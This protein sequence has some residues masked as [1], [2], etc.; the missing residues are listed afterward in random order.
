MTRI[1]LIAGLLVSAAASGAEQNYKYIGDIPSACPIT[2]KDGTTPHG[3]R[4]KPQQAV[5]LAAKHSLVK[6]NSVFEQSVYADENNYYIIK[7]AF[8]PMNANADA[9][10]ING[11][12][13][14]VII[15]KQ[16]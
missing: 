2:I 5:E 8:G 13:G 9:V 12:S 7:P 3:F 4:V 11:R 1:Y 10:V 15:R 16:K 6:C 14:R